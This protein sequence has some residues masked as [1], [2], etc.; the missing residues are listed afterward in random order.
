MRGVAFLWLTIS[1]AAAFALGGCA[2]TEG[3]V[4]IV[5]TS[6]S[7]GTAKVAGAEETS[8]QVTVDDQRPSKDTVGHKTDGF[9][10]QWA[11]ITADNNAAQTLQSAIETELKS[12]GFIISATGVPVSVTL[13]KFE[14]RF[15]LGVWSGT[16]EAEIVMNA[17]V[18]NSSGNIIYT[19]VID[20]EGIKKGIEVMSSAN[21][22]LTLDRA[23]QNGVTKLFSDGAFIAALQTAAKGSAQVRA[24]L[25]ENPSPS[26]PISQPAS[27]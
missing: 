1:L 19:K 13:T 21:A 4:D 14:N 27:T 18:K 11:K 15:I 26:Q 24:N 17:V 9:G 5:Y 2:L 10:I 16:S 20:A 7:P 12:R 8:V 6:M 3:H 22:Q 25:P 23:L